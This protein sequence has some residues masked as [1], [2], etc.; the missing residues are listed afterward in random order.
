MTASNPNQISTED[1][2]TQLDTETLFHPGD[3]P[4]A[5]IYRCTGCDE[6]SVKL[7]TDDVQLPPCKGCTEK[8][9]EASY[10]RIG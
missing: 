5:G 2:K 3:K 7:E 6:T 4:G 1:A 10:R 9:Q 8:N